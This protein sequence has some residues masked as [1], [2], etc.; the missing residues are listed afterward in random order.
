MRL[1]QTNIEVARLTAR[2]L[3]T[4]AIAKELHL[5]HMTVGTFRYR[6]MRYYGVQNVAMLAHLFLQKKLIKNI[7]A[8]RSTT[9]SRRNNVHNS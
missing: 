5:T 1:S 7:Y 6:A 8:T 2:G 9:S 4:K 3:S